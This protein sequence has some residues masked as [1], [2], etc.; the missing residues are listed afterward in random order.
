VNEVDFSVD[1]EEEMQVD[2][3]NYDSHHSGSVNVTSFTR[4]EVIEAIKSCNFNKGLSPD[5]F[6]RTVL[7]SNN[8]LEKKVVDEVS[9]ALNVASI[10]E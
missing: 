1:E 3:N 5:C 2:T 10:P 9:N 8:Q 6:Y 7:Q 4:E